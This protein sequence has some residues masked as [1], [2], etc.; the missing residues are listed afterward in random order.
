MISLVIE[1]IKLD[2]GTLGLNF[3]TISDRFFL[4]AKKYAYF[5]RQLFSKKSENKGN[6]QGQEFY[7]PNKYGYVG[8][9]RI[10]VDSTFL[11]GVIPEEMNVLDIGAHAGEFAF[12]AKN[13]LKASKVTSIEPFSKTF[14]ILKKNNN[15]AYRY[16]ITTKKSATLK[17][18]KTSSQLN[19][20]NTDPSRKQEGVEKV[21]VIKL[22][23]FL[24]K[25]DENFDLLKIDTEGTE[26]DVLN[27]AGNSLLKFKY[28]LIEIE[29]GKDYFDKI[30]TVL[31]ILK[32]YEMKTIGKYGKNQRSVDVLFVKTAK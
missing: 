14:D 29:M 24:T 31:D 16:A 17:L 22:S 8:L 30:K 19:S 11:S 6:F 3:L 27:S 20:L 1:S 10:L 23:Q 13:V 28:I 9:Q 25:H 26:L 12:F 5:I 21:P 15:N 32:G 4:I 2:V 18:S 7:F